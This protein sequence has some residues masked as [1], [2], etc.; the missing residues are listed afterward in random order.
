MIYFKKSGMRE[1]VKLSGHKYLYGFNL[2]FGSIYT[3]KCAENQERESTE[4]MSCISKTH[5]PTAMINCI[6][7]VQLEIF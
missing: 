7:N 4:N 5:F 3:S 6:V 1:P 2:C